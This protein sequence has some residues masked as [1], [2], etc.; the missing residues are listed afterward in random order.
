MNWIKKFI[1]NEDGIESAEYAVIL[2]VVFTVGAVGFAALSE[3]IS[4][5]IS[6]GSDTIPS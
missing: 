4:N 2:G 5:L 1:I 6:K 3:R